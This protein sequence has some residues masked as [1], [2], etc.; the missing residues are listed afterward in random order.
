MLLTICLILCGTLVRAQQL[1]SLFFNL[2]TDSLK[3]GTHNYI[4]VEGRY[5]DGSYLPL[6]DKDVKFTSSY[7]KFSGNSLF[8]DSA[9]KVEKVKVK[10]QAIKNAALS[11][12]IIIYIKQYE[13]YERLPTVE[14][15]LKGE[16][17][18]KRK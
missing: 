6:G 14:E 1:D 5:S 17:K 2:Y 11:D 18:K 12:E 16:K 4:N 7:G 9:I 8:I 15:V 3:K 10:V 13:P